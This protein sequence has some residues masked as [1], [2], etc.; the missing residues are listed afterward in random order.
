MAT[1]P[2]PRPPEDRPPR[3]AASDR[4][5]D[6]QAA[7]VTD[8]RAILAEWSRLRAHGRGLGDPETALRYIAKRVGY[9]IA[10]DPVRALIEE[11]EGRG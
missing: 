5:R 9:Y 3:S 8:V 6:H 2:L 1:P 7:I 4:E 11:V 10:A